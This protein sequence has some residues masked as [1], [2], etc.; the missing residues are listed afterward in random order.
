MPVF[1]GEVKR[2]LR[3][4]GHF[5]FADFRAAQ[6]L[7]RLQ[8][9]LVESG[10]TIIEKE[11]ITPQVL[12]ALRLDSDRKSALIQGWVNQRLTGTFRQFAG[13]EGSDIFVGFQNG[14][15]SYV[16]YVIQNGIPPENGSPTTR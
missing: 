5:L 8:A 11:D 13:I 7:D 15:I 9:Q 6:D 14:T 2:V 16:R 12:E 10:M 4:G 3:P 1:L